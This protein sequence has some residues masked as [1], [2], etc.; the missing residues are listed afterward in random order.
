MAKHANVWAIRLDKQIELIILKD[1]SYSFNNLNFLEKPSIEK[2]TQEFVEH[3]C[4]KFQLAG[5][6]ID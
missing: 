4:K 3:E 5:L 1:L 6:V 2:K